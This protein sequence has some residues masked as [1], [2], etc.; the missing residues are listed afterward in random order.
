MAIRI[1]DGEGDGGGRGRKKKKEGKTSKVLPNS[2]PAPLYERA[3]LHESGERKE[4]DY[5]KRDDQGAGARG[6]SGQ[7]TNRCT[8]RVD[9]RPHRGG[10]APRRSCVLCNVGV[11]FERRPVQLIGELSGQR[12]VST[13]SVG[14]YHVAIRHAP[15]R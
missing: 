1:R 3:I 2:A 6:R 14:L 11:G 4:R 7:R 5:D 15:A 10:S 12:P 8:F 9:Q 13:N